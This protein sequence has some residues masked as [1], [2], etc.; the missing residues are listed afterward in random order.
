MLWCFLML[1]KACSWG[2]GFCAFSFFSHIFPLFFH[3]HVVGAW[4]SA[5]TNGNSLVQ[6]R[7]LDWDTDGPF[8]EYPTVLVYHPTEGGKLKTKQTPFSPGQPKHKTKTNAGHPFAAVTWAGLVGT[9]TGFSSAEVGIC[10]K[11]WIHYDGHDSR[12]GTPFT[13]VLRDILQVTSTPAPPYSLSFNPQTNQETLSLTRFHAFVNNRTVRCN[14][15]RSN[16]T[17]PRHPQNM[18]NLRR[19][20]RFHKQSNGCN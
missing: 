13:F 8:Q 12:F 6:L 18:F 7:A 11:V 17:N 1:E 4:D 10:E 19:G 9:I 16:P 3:S 14:Q 5:V 20:R 15:R 2:H